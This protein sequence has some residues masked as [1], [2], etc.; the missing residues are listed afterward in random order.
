MSYCPTCGNG[1]ATSLDSV[2]EIHG[3]ELEATH[4]CFWET[5]THCY[6]KPERCKCES[7][8]MMLA[9]TI[10]AERLQDLLL[11][12]LPGWERGYTADPGVI[13]QTVS[14]GVELP[15][16]ENNW[17]QEVTVGLRAGIFH[18]T[19]YGYGIASQT[20]NAAWPGV[21]DAL[22]MIREQTSAVTA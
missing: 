11:Q 3:I 15:T 1:I 16:S 17:S 2:D 10:T 6:D 9:K 4:H 13:N 22:D 19:H 5:C 7:G 18:T 20:S 8:P 14:A 12:L 21:V